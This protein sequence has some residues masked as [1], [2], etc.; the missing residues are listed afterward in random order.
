M[1]ISTDEERQDCWVPRTMGTRLYT[2]VHASTIQIYFRSESGA[3]MGGEDEG[4]V[5]K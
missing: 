4:R 5:G 1:E 3:G 2:D